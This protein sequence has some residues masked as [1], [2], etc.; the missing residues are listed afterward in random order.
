LT[1]TIPL[2][3]A[4]LHTAMQFLL[5]FEE[6]A[7]FLINNLTNYG[8][9]LTDHHSS[10]D[11]KMLT[12]NST[13][14]AVF[15]LTRRG[16]LLVQC[17]GVF[18]PQFVLENIVSDSLSIRGFVG[19]WNSVYPVYKAYKNQCRQ[20]KPS[21]YSKEILY[22]FQFDDNDN[23]L[24]H[25]SRVRLLKECDFDKWVLLN[26]RYIE[27]LGI[28][29]DLTASQAKAQFLT[30][31]KNKLWWGMFKDNNLVSISALNSNNKNIGQVG[32]IFTS[33][34]ERR[35]GY[36]KATMLH[37]LNDCKLIHQHAK[38]ILFTADIDLPAKKLYESIGYIKI[39][40]FALI[41]S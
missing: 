26:N 17:D 7:Q 41:L 36:S 33:E 19:D 27:E 20:Y 37:M 35:K 4:N 23:S 30:A 13:V 1:K 31:T 25:D 28:P 16:N 11:F 6:S 3:N 10:G 18:D 5:R 12:Y 40:Y 21:F 22:R 8:P 9:H 24:I 38:S 29:R 2:E 39:G 15:C 32:G 14:T 34:N